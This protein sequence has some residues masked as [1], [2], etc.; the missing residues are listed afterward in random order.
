MTAKVIDTH[1]HRSLLV[2]GEME[3]LT[4]VKVI[5]S[6]TSENKEAMEKFKEHL[7]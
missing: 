5:M 2:Q 7:L 1:Y 6:C 4:E 3:I